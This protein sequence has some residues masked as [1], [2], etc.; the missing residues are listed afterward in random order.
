ML[1]EL[2]PR[3]P[4]ILP[5][6]IQTNLKKSFT[7]NLAC[8]EK[9]GT[10]EIQNQKCMFYLS[11]CSWTGDLRFCRL[12]DLLADNSHAVSPGYAPTHT[13]PEQKFSCDCIHRLLQAML[14]LGTLMN[15]S[16]LFFPCIAF[17]GSCC[18]SSYLTRGRKKDQTGRERRLVKMRF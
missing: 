4:L 5:Y 3:R 7:N 13:T 18:S 16:A 2:G 14:G 8:L 12:R 15:L 6:L 17:S 9:E 11:C 10:L 1:K